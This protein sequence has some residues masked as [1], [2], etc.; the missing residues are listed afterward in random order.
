MPT[1]QFSIHEKFFIVHRIIQPARVQDVV[2][3]YWEI[4]DEE[5]D[6]GVEQSLR[7]LHKK[8]KDEGKLISV[9]RGTYVLDERGMRLAAK[10]IGKERVI[11]NARLFLM[12]KQRKKY[13]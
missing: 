9:R 2:K 11:D 13:H 3:Y 8:L 6:E 12:K 4:W 1:S 10:F 5:E 7:D